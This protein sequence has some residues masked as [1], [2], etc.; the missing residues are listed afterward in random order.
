MP[1]QYAA[2]EK[3]MAARVGALFMEEG[4]GRI[5]TAVE[6]VLRRAE[7]IS[8]VVWFCPFSML[9]RVREEVALH[10]AGSRNFWFFFSIESMSRNLAEISR[11][12]DLI[13][14]RTF[15]ILDESHFIKGPRAK[16]SRRM[17]RVAGRARYRLILSATPITQGIQDLYNQFRFL[18]ERILGYR[19]FYAF[20][21]NHLEFSRGF[22]RRVVRAHN[23]DYLSAKI[24]PYTCQ[25]T[26]EECAGLPE[27]IYLTHRFEMTREQRICYEMTKREILDEM[28]FS[29]NIIFLLFIRLQQV[30][31]GLYVSPERR[32]RRIANGRGTALN[33]ALRSLGTTARTVIWVKF[34]FEAA[35]V[36]AE[37]P[38]EETVM[39]SGTV[40]AEEREAALEAFRG[41][42]RFLVLNLKLGKYNLD[43]SCAD[44]VLFYSNSFDYADRIRAENLCR[45]SDGRRMLFIDLTCR[46]SIDEKI[47]S[48]LRKKSHLVR[49]FRN[50]LDEIHS[51]EE[52]ARWFAEL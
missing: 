28:S 2:V 15:M 52:A 11:A 10:A 51:R 32:E 31:S 21:S 49:E 45:R 41:P 5:R 24:A 22:P 39:L 8:R 38:P 14:D 36:A 9:D 17:I 40:S 25:V 29:G 20:S 1:H 37:L 26:R 6:L 46:N 27:R 43:L 12:F 48:C 34:R 47:D 35:D 13:D 18:S 19:S 3:L 16:R 44:S 42:C 7:R 23:V 50:S 30:L 33:G 4:T